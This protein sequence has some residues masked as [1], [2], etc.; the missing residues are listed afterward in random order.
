MV[1]VV[2]YRYGILTNINIYMLV[3]I[4]INHHMVY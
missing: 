3:L 1:L 2:G 4:S